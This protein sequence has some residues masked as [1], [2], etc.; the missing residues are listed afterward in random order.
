M[1][2][3][4][5]TAAIALAAGL[6]MSACATSPPSDDQVA[7]IQTACAID[8]GVRPAVTALLAV[9][10]LATPTEAAAVAAAR[11]VI[12]PVCANPSAPLQTSAI[13]AVSSASMQLVTMAAQ[14]QA[15]RSASQ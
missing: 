11:A 14:L 9:P 12:D 13:S 15:R 5:V 7:K 1:K 10:D 3:T 2:R 8:A 4:V 6:M